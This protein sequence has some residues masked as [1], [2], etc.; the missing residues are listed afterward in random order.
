MSVNY[1]KLSKFFLFISVLCIS[2]VTVSTLFPFIVGKYVWFRLSVDLAFLFFLLGLLL[3]DKLSIISNQLL[4][5]FRKPIVIAVSI[6]ILI[7]LLACFFSVDPK[8]SFWSNFERGEGGFQMLHFYIFFLLLITLL[9]EEDWQ[10]LFIFALIGGLGMAFYGLF[11]GFGFQNFVGIKFSDSGFRFQGS[12]GNPAYVAAYSIFMIF[13][14]LYLLISKYKKHLFSFG[15]SMLWFLILLFSIVFFAAATRGAFLGLITA[16]FFFFVYLIFTGGKKLR[17]WLI[18]IIIFIILTVGLM[19]GFKDSAFI[20]SLPGSRIF[21]ISI[22]AQTFQHRFI[23]WETAIE[24]WKEKPLLGWGPENYL[25][26]FD[27]KFNTKYF[28]PS[29]DFGAWFDRAHSIY[30]DYLAETGILGLLSFLAIFF[31]FYWQ[32][33]KKG[34]SLF[35]IQGALIFSIPIAYLVQGIVLF[36]VLPIYMNIFLFLAFVTYKFQI[37]N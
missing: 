19:I 29:E 36:D 20:K 5:V 28:V 12:I 22:S 13:Y 24:G 16:T 18:P 27:Q 3:Q 35:F 25:K 14:A 34:R 2:V 32:F 7:F 26:I 23:M 21:D 1:F 6:F 30:F 8:M 4:T 9:R 11:A 37:K 17:K 10:K 33:F 15:A 31:V